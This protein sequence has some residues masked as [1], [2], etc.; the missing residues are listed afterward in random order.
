[1]L[2]APHVTGYLTEHFA[3]DAFGTLPGYEA[4]GGYAAARKAMNEMYKSQ[5]ALVLDTVP[6]IAKEE[7]LA[8]LKSLQTRWKQIGIT[9]YRNYLVDSTTPATKRPGIT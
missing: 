8:K 4:Q 3:D 9:S 6:E 7:N 1:M 5:V 2:K